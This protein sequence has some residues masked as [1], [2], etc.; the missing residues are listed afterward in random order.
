QLEAEGGRIP[1]SSLPLSVRYPIAEGT[2]DLG[3][4]YKNLKEDY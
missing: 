4:D 1:V 2:Q 3:A